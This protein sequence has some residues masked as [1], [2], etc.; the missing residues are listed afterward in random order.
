[1]QPASALV[2]DEPP[3]AH[4]E[5]VAS[6]MFWRGGLA[7]TKSL[8]GLAGAVGKTWLTADHSWPGRDGRSDASISDL[9]PTL[10]IG[11]MPLSADAAEDE[12]PIGT[13]LPRGCAAY[14][15]KE[16]INDKPGYRV[17]LRRH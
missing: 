17:G 9:Q 4:L 1:M 5:A 13:S 2:F 16:M 11:G 10:G 7:W 3:R 15:E 8:L 6:L 12:D 14:L